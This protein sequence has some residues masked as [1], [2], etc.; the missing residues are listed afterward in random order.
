MRS[1]FKSF[2]IGYALYAYKYFQ[3]RP[4]FCYAGLINS[5]L[6]LVCN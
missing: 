4:V 1:R 2:T 5:D 3:E 6:D